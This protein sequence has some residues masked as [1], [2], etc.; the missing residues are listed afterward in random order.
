MARQAVLVPAGMRGVHGRFMRWR[1]SHAGRRPIPESLWKAAAE[2]ARE[3]GVFQTAKAL[4]LD[5]VKLKQLTTS[6]SSIRGKAVRPPA[7]R[8][9][10]PAAFMELLAPGTA[11]ASECLIELEGPH[12]K[13][14]IQWKGATGA[15]LAS[16]SRAWWES[17]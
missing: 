3:H 4:R 8:P 2:L 7:G 15:D 5:Y 16:L 6:A 13:M 12:G 1:Q 14:R 17:A 9:T 10:G 11:G